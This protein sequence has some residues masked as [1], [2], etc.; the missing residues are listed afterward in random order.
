MK[1]KNNQH[2]TLITGGALVLVAAATV[3]GQD[4]EAPAESKSWFTETFPE[5]ITSG[6]VNFNARLRY[7]YAEQDGFAKDSNAVTI[8]SRLGYTTGDLYGF[9]GMLEFED[10]TAIGR[11][12]YNQAGLNGQ[13]NRPVV[14]D[15]EGTEVNQAW[16]SFSKWDTAAKLGRQR[17]ILDNARFVG[18]VGWRQNEQTFD[19]FTIN[20]KSVENLSLTYAYIANVNRIFGDDHAAGDWASDSHVLNVS[21]DGFNGYAKLTAYGYFLDFESDAPAASSNTIGGSVTG[22]VPI[23]DSDV[24]I[25]YRAEFAY[26]EDTGDNPVDYS[27]NYYHLAVDSGYKMFNFGAGYEVLGSDDGTIGF[28]TPLATGHAFNGWADVFLGTPADGLEDIYAFVGAN[29]PG[30]VPVKVFY[31]KFDAN[32]GSNDYGQEID[33]VASKKFGKNWSVLAKYAYYDEEDVFAGR[34][35]FWLQGE[36]NF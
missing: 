27:A 11:D 29:L 10:V 28:A 12:N 30:G 7:E 35:K 4:A 31:H 1:Y 34:S 14:A 9:K 21:Y 3:F 25:N 17:F 20:N 33:V 16:L 8:R 13:G 5:F 2:K 36:F 18:N 15:P 23:G 26:Q 32:D 19:S 22:G 24:K 6:K